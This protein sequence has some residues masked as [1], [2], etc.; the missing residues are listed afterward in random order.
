V[1]GEVYW[2]VT[3]GDQTQVMDFT[4]ARDVLGRELSGAEVQWS[5]S[6]PM[7]WPVIAQAFGLPVE[8]PGSRFG[9]PESSQS[10][11]SYT[12]AIFW[13]VVIVLFICATIAFDDGDGDGGGGVFI[14]RGGGISGGK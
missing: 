13:V 6:S 14:F 8:G 10:S 4:H 2:K 1:L 3:V 11:G 7:P 12:S 9:A 5:F